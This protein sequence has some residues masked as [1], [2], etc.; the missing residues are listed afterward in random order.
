[1]EWLHESKDSVAGTLNA[2]IDSAVQ[3]TRP[4][5][6]RHIQQSRRTRPGA[7]PAEIIGVLGGRFTAAV[8]CSGAAAGG[9]AAAPGVGTGLSLALSAGDAIGFTGLAALYV[10]ALA[11]IYDVPITE[12][13]RRRTLLLGVMIGDTGARTVQQMAGRTAPYWGRRIVGGI[14]VA[15]LVQI[16]KVLGKNFVTKYGTKQ[17]ILILGKQVP[18]GLGAVIGAAGNAAFA[19]FT[20]RSARTAFGPPPT[21][22]PPHLDGGPEPGLTVPSWQPSAGPSDWHAGQA[23]VQLED[24]PSPSRSEH[25][26][27]DDEQTETWEQGIEDR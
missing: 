24:K 6:I 3:I 21:E 26:R 11:E 15:T 20:T 18:F 27:L 13:E 4:K 7:L 2:G 5:I 1:M 12:L 17:G 8:A 19:R 23:A 10:F 16:N 9:A 25:G 22:W 14:P